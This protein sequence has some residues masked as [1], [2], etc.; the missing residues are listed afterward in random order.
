MAF[1]VF[2]VCNE[3]RLLLFCWIH[4]T[5]VLICWMFFSLSFTRHK[6]V[7]WIKV[8]TKCDQ[9]QWYHLKNHWNFKTY[10]STEW[11]MRAIKEKDIR[12][13]C[14]IYTYINIM[15][16]VQWQWATDLSI[17][18][19]HKEKYKLCLFVIFFFINP[20]A[21]KTITKKNFCNS[22]GIHTVHILN[23]LVANGRTNTLSKCAAMNVRHIWV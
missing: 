4:N 13:T 2:L 10:Q 20:S 14:Y 21:T 9:A 5:V 18:S 11:G 16:I 12:T 1:C 19:I 22:Y 23:M 6:Q 15:Y 7:I 8:H 17:A 3:Q